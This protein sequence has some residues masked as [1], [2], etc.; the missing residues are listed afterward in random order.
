MRNQMRKDAF[1]LARKVRTFTQGVG[2]N[3]YCSDHHS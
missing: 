2:I 3:Q 1:H